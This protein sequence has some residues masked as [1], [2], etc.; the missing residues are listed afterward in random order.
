MLNL[1]T[2]NELTDQW[3]N[4][5]VDGPLIGAVTAEMHEEV[6]GIT[7][8]EH[9]RIK[10]LKKSHDTRDHMDPME[11]TLVTLSEQAATAIMVERGTTEFEDTREA[12]LDGARIA[13]NAA[14]EISKK[15][16]RPVANSQNFLPAAAAT[17]ALPK[18]KARAKPKAV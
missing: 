17:Q 3:A 4:R 16:G 10:E 12:S 7:P 13:G 9:K 18:P 14:V 5:G 8:A 11:L 6:F 15:L 2:R 1:S